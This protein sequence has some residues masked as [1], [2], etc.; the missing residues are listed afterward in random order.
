MQKILLLL[1][2]IIHSIP[3]SSQQRVG[4]PNVLLILVDDLGTQDLNC[5]GSTDLATPNLD[6]LAARGVRFNQFYAGA[7]VCSPS[8]AAL[9]TGKTNLGAGL[10]GNVPLSNEGGMPSE[11]YTMAEMMKD[12]GYYTAAI[13]KWHLGN[14]APKSPNGQGF[15]HFLGHYVGCIDNYSH[16]YYWGGPNKHDLH[17]NAEEIYKPGEYFA[18]LMVSEIKGIVDQKRSQPFFIYWAINMPHYPYQG[19]P[20]WLEYYKNSPSPRREYAAF[21][22]T[23]DEYIGKVYAQLADHGMLE[24]TIIIF[25]SD[26]GHSYEE[27]A[28]YGG[29][30]AGPYRGGK[31][32]MFEGG[33][34]VPAI[35]SYPRSLPVNE[36]REQMVSSMD[37]FPTIAR[38]TGATIRKESLEGIDITDMIKS[39][40]VS[41][42]NRDIHWQTETYDDKKAQWAVRY[43]DWKLI[44]N[45]RDP[46]AKKDLAA[47]DPLFLV[48]LREDISETRNLA[49]E[50]T[51]KVEELL[52]LHKNWLKKVTLANP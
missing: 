18:D 49:S 11:Q 8:R 44:G 46:S 31:F 10:A 1:I 21:V 26:H 39:A 47:S 35:I 40:K 41:A 25:Q 34:R 22:S 32:S 24:N 45:P 38:L 51:A 12:N 36:T 48:N 33:I 20:K 7:P 30:N 42:P 43:G 29:G 13:G 50:Q 14:S 27:R 52:D 17:R 16:F 6:K 2:L 5:Y 9:L 4:K 23:M 19:L 3:A 15:D 28:F 37:W